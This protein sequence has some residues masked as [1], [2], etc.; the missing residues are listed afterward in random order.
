MDDPELLHA[1]RTTT[2]TVHLSSGTVHVR[3]NNAVPLQLPRPLAIITA[4]NPASEIR[5][6]A[7]NEAANRRLSLALQHAGAR[8]FPAVAGGTGPEAD[9]WTEPGFAVAGLLRAQ[10]VALGEQFGQNA[11]VWIDAPGAE[12][13]V[14]RPG[15][16][17]C[18]PGTVLR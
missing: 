15:F 4:Y 14:T 6:K 9:R 7:E 3:P 13:L 2:W 11:I 10:V 18:E 16:C 8:C 17:G 1:Y 12:L 5:S